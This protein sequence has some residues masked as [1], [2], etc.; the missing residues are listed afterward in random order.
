M[1]IRHRAVP[2][3]AIPATAPGERLLEDF[4][5]A[6]AAVAGDVDGSTVESVEVGV[7]GSTVLWFVTIESSYV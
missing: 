2:A 7:E 5:F 1:A 4:W 6:L 3:M